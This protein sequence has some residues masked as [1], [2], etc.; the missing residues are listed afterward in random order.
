M[1]SLYT[2]NGVGE[3]EWGGASQ[4][5]GSPHLLVVEKELVI[6]RVLLGTRGIVGSPCVSTAIYVFD[7]LATIVSPAAPGCEA[8]GMA[9]PSRL[10][11]RALST[12]AETRGTTGGGS[13]HTIAVVD[14]LCCVEL[15]W[16]HQRRHGLYNI[17]RFHK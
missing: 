13:D 10:G 3:P 2:T 8:T 5:L 1:C 7:A 16:C 6:W 12:N 17:L 4:S 11:V 14:V 15:F 9:D